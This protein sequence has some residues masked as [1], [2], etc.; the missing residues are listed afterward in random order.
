MKLIE[1]M[2]N[3]ILYSPFSMDVCIPVEY[4]NECDRCS[5]VNLDCETCK[6]CKSSVTRGPLDT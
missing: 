1:M 2:K 5:H 6:N 3:G 4:R